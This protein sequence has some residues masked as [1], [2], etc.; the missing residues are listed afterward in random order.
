[1]RNRS[2]MRIRSCREGV[3]GNNAVRFKSCDGSSYCT[4]LEENGCTVMVS[5]KLRDPSRGEP[6][7]QA[8]QPLLPVFTIC[9]NISYFNYFKGILHTFICVL[10]TN[11]LTSRRW[12][13]SRGM[14]SSL[15]QAEDT[16]TGRPYRTQ[17]IFRIANKGW[18]SGVV[19]R[20]GP[21]ASAEVI[22]FQPEYF[23][24]QRGSVFF[25]VI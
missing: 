24:T 25:F 21:N 3:C 2:G 6:S 13:W 1:M 15:L 7:G 22:A 4:T 17:T 8:T 18:R 9:L 20:T 23:R 12:V 10:W 5:R 19:N 16:P 11:L 14:L